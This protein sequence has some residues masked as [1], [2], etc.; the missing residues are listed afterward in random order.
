MKN[1]TAVWL[2]WPTEDMGLAGTA[3]NGL[4]VLSLPTSTRLALPS[5]DAMSSIWSCISETHVVSEVHSSSLLGLSGV[6]SCNIVLLVLLLDLR[7][8][9]NLLL[10]LSLAVLPSE[11]LEVCRELFVLT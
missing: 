3:T 10:L 8:L 2:D 1:S 11:S 4:G 9:E 5:F 7:L 6:L